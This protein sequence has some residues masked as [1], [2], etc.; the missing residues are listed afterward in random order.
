MYPRTQKKS[1]I[2]QKKKGCEILSR[3][4]KLANDSALLSDAISYSVKKVKQNNIKIKNVVIL[5]CNSICI[6]SKIIDK[7]LKKIMIKIHILLRQYQN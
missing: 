2:Q 1:C 4:K 6:N 3:P 5:L 7:A